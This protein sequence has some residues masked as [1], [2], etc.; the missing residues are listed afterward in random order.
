MKL[1]KNV[2]L[3]LLIAHSLVITPAKAA[4][5]R[6]FQSHTTVAAPSYSERLS[7]SLKYLS[8]QVGK[9][10][11]RHK[12]VLLTS[13]VISTMILGTYYSFS[14]VSD[15]GES[16]DG[17]T[18]AY[19]NITGI[20]PPSFP[21]EAIFNQ[22]IKGCNDLPMLFDVPKSSWWYTFTPYNESCSTRESILTDIQG[23]SVNQLYDFLRSFNGTWSDRITI[24]KDWV[25]TAYDALGNFYCSCHYRIDPTITTCTSKSVA[26]SL[27]L[28]SVPNVYGLGLNADGTI[29][30][31]YLGELSGLTG[32]S[33]DGLRCPTIVQG[34]CHL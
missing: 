9:T 33:D 29:Q 25:T 8:E 17:L 12:R 31:R 4:E 28:P 11:S 23:T 10:V 5:I 21:F 13:A 32:G 2:V 18:T 26:L 16:D 3:A 20:C 7:Q 24:S 1:V 14:M 34:D 15:S 19:P 30:E 27:R 22:T 6:E